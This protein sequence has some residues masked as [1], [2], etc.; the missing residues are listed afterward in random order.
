[1]AD[2]AATVVA[3]AAATV[4]AEA[5]VAGMGLAEAVGFMDLLP[6]DWAAEGFMGLLP[7]VAWLT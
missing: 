7:M 3:E 1:M 4:G 6:M 5:A 2:A